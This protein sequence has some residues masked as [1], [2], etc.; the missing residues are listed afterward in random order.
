MQ[1]DAKTV[2]A[3]LKQLPV[4][5]RAA[6]TNLRAMIKRLAPSLKEVM[7]YGM[8]AF[9]RDGEPLIALAS[10]KHYMAIYIC[11]SPVMNRYRKQLAK[12]DVGKGCIR[13]RHYADLPLDVIEKMIAEAV[14][15]G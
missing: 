4:E 6:L 12:L 10:Q 14:L 15:T 7:A 3:Y 9:A 1:S 5:R 8:P 11:Y 13:F 2:P